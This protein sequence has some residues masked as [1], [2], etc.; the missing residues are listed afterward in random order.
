MALP[1]LPRRKKDRSSD[2]VPK[3]AIDGPVFSLHSTR[4]SEGEQKKERQ[5]PVVRVE[6]HNTRKG[7]SLEYASRA[8]NKA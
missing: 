6:T 2:C 1:S 7:S 3:R 8:S 5:K 4:V